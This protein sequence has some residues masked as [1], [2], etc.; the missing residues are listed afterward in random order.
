M[1]NFIRAYNI[2]GKHFDVPYDAGT[3][4][5]YYLTRAAEQGTELPHE[6]RQQY[7]S[8]NEMYLSFMDPAGQI[9]NI[10]FMQSSSKP[11]WIRIIHQMYFEQGLENQRKLVLIAPEHIDWRQEFRK[12][13]GRVHNGEWIQQ[14]ERKAKGLIHNFDK[15]VE[16]PV[17]KIIKPPSKVFEET[18]FIGDDRPSPDPRRW[19]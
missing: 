17:H 5:F 9:I 16:A 7:R 10:R 19:R 11:D 12:F 4:I 18:R 8:L 6:W 2:K 13:V 3:G 15:F 1:E 14:S